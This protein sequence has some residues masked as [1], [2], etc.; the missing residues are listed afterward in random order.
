MHRRLWVSYSTTI[1]RHLC[2]DCSSEC[3]C[4]EGWEQ[5][6]YWFTI[7]EDFK[8]QIGRKKLCN[9]FII[10]KIKQISVCM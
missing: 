10:S 5:S 1:G 4:L 6:L 9:Y 3:I 2:K 7:K 8:S